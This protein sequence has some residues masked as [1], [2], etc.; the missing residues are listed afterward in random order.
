MNFNISNRNV[1]RRVKQRSTRLLDV[2]LFI[3]YMRIYKA[4]RNA[5]VTVVP[6]PSFEVRDKSAL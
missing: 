1:K 6:T 2:L 3:A 5:T 4:Y